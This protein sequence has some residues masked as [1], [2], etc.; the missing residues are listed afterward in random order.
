M[1]KKKNSMNSKKLVWLSANTYSGL[2]ECLVQQKDFV[3]RGE[4][5]S[6]RQKRLNQLKPVLLQLTRT[7][8]LDN[9][10][11]II[12]LDQQDLYSKP[13]KQTNFDMLE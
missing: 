4:L 2:A 3:D 7:T 5:T 12:H 8:W 1:K 6:K 13:H 10:P 11:V 9:H